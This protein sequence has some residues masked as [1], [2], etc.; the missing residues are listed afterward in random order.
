M[1][2]KP[3][4]DTSVVQRGLDRLRRQA[5][6]LRDRAAKLTAEG[7]VAEAASQD[8]VPIKTGFLQGSATVVDD[9]DRFTFGFNANYAAPV[10]ETHPSKSKFLLNAIVEEGKRIVEAATRIAFRESVKKAGGRER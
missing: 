5:P 2:E 8:R 4:I 6:A 9:G 1:A 3:S 10:H 7:I